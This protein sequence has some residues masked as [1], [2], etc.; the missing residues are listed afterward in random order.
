MN[1]GFCAYYYDNG[2]V[3]FSE[4]SPSGDCD[5]ERTSARLAQ[6]I[7][8][9]RF[10]TVCC[11][12]WTTDSIIWSQYPLPAWVD[13]DNASRQ[14][15]DILDHIRQAVIQYVT[16]YADQHTLCDAAI[17]AAYADYMLAKS[18]C[19]WSDFEAAEESIITAAIYNAS[20]ARIAMVKKL[21]K[22]NGYIYKKRG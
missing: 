20:A 14:V 9:R 2:Q 11:P 4:P 8:G 6:A 10:I 21:E 19:G 16:I 18:P 22:V 5:S 3:Y 13:K 1:K 17:N 7:T 12:D 15:G